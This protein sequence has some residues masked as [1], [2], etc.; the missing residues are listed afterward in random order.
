M[1]EPTDT[2]LMQEYADSRS[3]SAFAQLTRRHLNLVYSVA[4]RYTGNAHDAQDIAQ[5]VFLILARKI[6]A[7]RRRASLTG[8]LYETTRLTSRQLLRT[9]T[10]QQKRDQEAFMQSAPD[11]SATNDAWQQLAPHLEAAMSRLAEHERALLA[12]RFYENKTGAEAAA[13]LGIGEQ[14]AHKRTARALD[15]LRKFFNRRGVALTAALIA[16]ALSANAVL[17]APASLVASIT[18][19]AANGSAIGVSAASLAQATLKTLFWAK[20]KSAIGFAAVA[21]VVSGTALVALS[22]KNNSPKPA[23]P[24]AGITAPASDISTVALT[25]I[26]EPLADTMKFDLETP[27]GGVALQADGKIVVGSTLFGRF[28]DDASGSIGFYTRG[29]FRLNPDGSLDR[30]FFCNVEMPASAAQ[31]A[32]VDCLPDGRIFLT[33][34]FGTVDGEPRPN[35]AMLLPDGRVDESF[36]PW[37]GASNQPPPFFLPKVDHP[38]TWSLTSYQGG[39]IPAMWMPENTVSIVSRSIYQT[40]PLWARLASF[41]LDATGTAI[42]TSDG[43][44]NKKFA[45]TIETLGAN[46][47]WANQMIDWTREHADTN[48]P[49]NERYSK[50]YAGEASGKLKALFQEMPIELCS[51]AVKLPDGGAI[52]AVTAPEKIG[53][54]VGPG[55]LMRFDKNWQPD[56]SFTNQYDGRGCL[57]IKRQKDGK[58]LVAGVYGTLNGEDFTGLVR[59]NEDGSTDHSFHCETANSMEG[60]VMDM[61]IQDDGR[62]VICGFFSSVNGV[63]VPHIARINPDGSLDQTFHPS[64]ITMDRFNKDLREKRRVAVA[65]LHKTQAPVPAPSTPAATASAS[66]S[67]PASAPETIVITL[68]KIEATG[69]RIEFTGV[70]GRQYLLQANDSLRSPDWKTISTNQAAADGAG[71]FHDSDTANHPTR[72][73]RVATP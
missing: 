37:R 72:F 66:S 7:L 21:L 67:V 44:T 28:V 22:A 16:A 18:A 24:V 64:F 25:P 1:A 43:D 45:Q 33:G 6:P 52:L 14:A 2:E 31:M 70:G 39:A 60:R 40:E 27:P 11:H 53:G 48:L 51:Y 46:G 17:A 15:K 62:I 71:V 58:I 23:S 35:Y 3:E 63:E 20:C 4:L 29:A 19:A 32:H 69:A 65:Q 56:F 57:N 41:R 59:L 8:W 54:R 5:A 36:V 13:L 49:Y 55:K 12:L 26:R 73:Y 42:E 68:M 34:L 38:T 50:M 9:R 10:R 61:A 30:S 47:F